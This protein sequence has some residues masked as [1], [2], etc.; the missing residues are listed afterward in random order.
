M[1]TEC[2]VERIELQPH[3]RRRVTVDFDGGWLSKEAGALLLR[4]ADTVFAVSR[5]LAGCF[6]DLR[7]PGRVEHDLEMLVR[8]RVMAIARGHEDPDDH[9]LLRDDPLFAP[10]VGR[11]DITG[12]DRPRDRGH[13]SAEPCPDVCRRCPN[14]GESP[15][16][17]PDDRPRTRWAGHCG[18][19]SPRWPRQNR[20]R[21]S[22]SGIDAA[23]VELVKY[24]G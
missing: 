14:R 4:E 24:P 19:R 6:P 9:D 7:D 22:I 17:R 11:E 10:A 8:Q 5:R 13:P 12:A 16:C 18:R 3:C 1:Q 15:N 23:E 21:G 20:K 2:S